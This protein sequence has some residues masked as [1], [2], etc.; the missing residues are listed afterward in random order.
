MKD[1][2]AENKRDMDSERLYQLC[3]AGTRRGWEEASRYVY[4]IISWKGWSLNP[5]EK[6]NLTQETLLYFI[7]GGLEQVKEPKAFKKLLSLKALGNVIDLKRKTPIRTV[8]VEPTNGP[9][10]EDPPTP[11]IPY[12]TPDPADSIFSNQAVSICHDI[13][14]SMKDDRCREILPR[15]FE[16]KA[17]GENIGRIAREMKKPVGTIASI[18]HRCLK[19]LQKHPRIRQLRELVFHQG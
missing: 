6:E 16:Y 2:T 15:Y 12:N 8:P 1:E 13:I 4:R 11:G 5:S 3:V 7:S 18:I 10:D 17:I 19:L 14:A 9:D